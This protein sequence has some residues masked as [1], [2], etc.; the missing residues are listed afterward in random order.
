MLRAFASAMAGA[1]VA[2]VFIS[3]H[4]AYDQLA[5]EGRIHRNSSTEVLK[6][7]ATVHARID[8]ALSQPDLPDMGVP[9]PGPRIITIDPD[10][11]VRPA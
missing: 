4:V 10:G 11:R 8:V 7:H 9:S 1:M 3:A 2:T 5:R 6:V